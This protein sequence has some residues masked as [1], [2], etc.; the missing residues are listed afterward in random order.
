VDRKTTSSH[1]RKKF[2][3]RSMEKQRGM[4]FGFQK[5]ATDVKNTGWI[6][7]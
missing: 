3:T 7:R 4:E 1:D 5:T 6:D 2:R